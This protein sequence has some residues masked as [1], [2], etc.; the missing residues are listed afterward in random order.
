MTHAELVIQDII[1]GYILTRAKIDYIVEGQTI[2]PAGYYGVVFCNDPEFVFPELPAPPGDDDAPNEFDTIVRQVEE[3]GFTMD[4]GY[5]FV[6]A[7]IQAGYNPQEDGVVMYW[8]LEH[9][10]KKLHP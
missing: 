3:F 8:F 4:Q 2:W 10:Y 9:V 5:R 7:C 6:C 1:P